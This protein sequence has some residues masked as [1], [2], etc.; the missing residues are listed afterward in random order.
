M[1]CWVEVDKGQNI[2]IFWVI[3]NNIIVTWGMGVFYLHIV[4]FITFEGEPVDTVTN[5]HVSWGAGRPIYNNPNAS[6]LVQSPQPSPPWWS[7]R[8]SLL[9]EQYVY[10]NICA[11]SAGE[12]ASPLSNKTSNSCW[13]YLLNKRRL[14]SHLHTA[15]QETS[16]PHMSLP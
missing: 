7:C 10:F 16:V 1:F 5:T 13:R 12:T 4:H 6:L 9:I 14:C 2:C 3:Y 8:G 11:L 15:G